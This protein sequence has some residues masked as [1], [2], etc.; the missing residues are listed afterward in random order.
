[1]TGRMIHFIKEAETGI[2]STVSN[3]NIYSVVDVMRS[4]VTVQSVGIPIYACTSNLNSF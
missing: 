1:M 4:K 3:V 2:F